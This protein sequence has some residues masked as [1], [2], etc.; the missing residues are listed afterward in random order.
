MRMYDA[1]GK[2][3]QTLRSSEKATVQYYNFGAGNEVFVINEQKQ[4]RLLD[5]RGNLLGGKSIAS[6]QGIA[7]IYSEASQSWFVLRNADKVTYLT[8]VRRTRR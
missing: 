6:D 4:T 3:I 7:L 8:T 5:R 2:A 1:A